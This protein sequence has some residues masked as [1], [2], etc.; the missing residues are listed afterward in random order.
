MRISYRVV[1]TG[2]TTE[3][4]WARRAMAGNDPFVVGDRHKTQM[5]H[6]H[7]ILIRNQYRFKANKKCLTLRSKEDGETTSRSR[8][9]QQ[10]ACIISD[11]SFITYRRRLVLGWLWRLVAELRRTTNLVIPTLKNR[12]ANLLRICRGL[13][14][15]SQSP[16]HNPSYIPWCT[17]SRV[18]SPKP[19]IRDGRRVEYYN[20]H[21]D[22]P[23]LWIRQNVCCSSV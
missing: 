14:D 2:D 11:K 10:W 22:S 23:N 7:S 12:I 18:W 21:W 17:E 5:P 13:D 9:A 8:T 6:Q 4:Y 20:W 3:A 1:M 16:E 15:P 19:R